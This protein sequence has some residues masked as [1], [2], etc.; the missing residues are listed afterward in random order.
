MNKW[1]TLLFLCLT[2]TTALVAC[3]S[4]GGGSN[5]S[6]QSGPNQVHMDNSNFVQST[7]TIK[8]GESLTLVADTFSPHVIA[9]GS[10]ENDSAKAAQEPGAP[11]IKDVQVGG[12]SSTTVGP[13]NTAGTFKL[14]CTVHQGMNLTVTVQ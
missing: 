4:T 8:K 12:N 10:W 1:L 9:N 6:N 7:I 3:G 13:F 2:L 14:Y 5:G 11:T